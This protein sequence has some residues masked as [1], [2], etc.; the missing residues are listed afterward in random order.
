MRVGANEPLL[1]FVSRSHI[2]CRCCF[3]CCC[4][5]SSRHVSPV[6]RNAINWKMRWGKID[7]QESISRYLDKGY[8]VLTSLPHTLFS[9]E[10]WSSPT[11]LTRLASMEMHKG[12]LLSTA[13]AQAAAKT[14]YVGVAA[15]SR[16]RGKI[17]TSPAPSIF[18][19]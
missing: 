13:A 11:K 4:H 3:C 15:Q 7:S 19:P 5:I 18:R 14:V 17:D 10:K 6:N 16:S 12:R 9:H 1:L 2:C 8:D